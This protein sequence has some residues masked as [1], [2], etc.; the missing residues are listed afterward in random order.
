MPTKQRDK[1]KW[2]THKQAAEWFMARKRIHETEKRVI[3]A[4]LKWWEGGIDDRDWTSI[5]KAVRAL[6][7]ARKKAGL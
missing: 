5:A 1:G 6:L 7:A 3:K 2:L 4:I